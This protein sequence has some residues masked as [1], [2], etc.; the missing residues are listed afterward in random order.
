MKIIAF[1]FLLPLLQNGIYPEA[2][3]ISPEI[4]SL[5]IDK[6]MSDAEL[7][8]IKHELWDQA[9]ITFDVENIKRSSN[10]QIEQISIAVDCHDGYS[11][12]T[13]YTFMKRKSRVGFYRDYRPDMEAF[14]IGDIRGKHYKHIK[15]TRHLKH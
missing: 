5:V 9:G 8:V 4:I 13:D 6:N 2:L 1:V 14:M 15:R 10:G 11:G 12:K 3:K 7:K